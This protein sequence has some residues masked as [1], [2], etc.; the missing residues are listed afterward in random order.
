M[1]FL[2]FTCLLLIFSNETT[3]TMN[4]NRR[5][6]KLTVENTRRTSIISLNSYALFTRFA[7]V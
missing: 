7:F 4:E 6:G 1:I 2:F 3:E 5:Q